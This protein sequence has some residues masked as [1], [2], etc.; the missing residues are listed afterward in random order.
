MCE[1]VD[2]II[3]MH[4]EENKEKTL[5]DVWLHRVFDKSF[6][7]FVEGLEGRAAPAEEDVAN[8]VSETQ[9]IL[10]SFKPVE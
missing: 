6:N 1:F 4:N 3:R 9:S 10:D 2:E 5:W 8:I 7:D